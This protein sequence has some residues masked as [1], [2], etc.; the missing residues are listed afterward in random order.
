MTDP[1]VDAALPVD[2]KDRLFVVITDQ[3]VTGN[4]PAQETMTRNWYYSDRIIAKINAEADLEVQKINADAAEYAG[5]K[6][7]AVNQAISAS[8][9][10]ELVAY[11]E[12]MQWNG[13][14]PTTYMGD[15]EGVPVLDVT[16]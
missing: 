6:E 7:A 14:L 13:A 2:N 1:G 9:T 15:G 11:Y 12:I 5:Q 8:L 3:T 4:S 16:P 10:P